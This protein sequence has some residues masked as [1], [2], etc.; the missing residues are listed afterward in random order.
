[1]MES[2]VDFVKADRRLEKSARRMLM[3]MRLRKAD[4]GSGDG[5][6]RQMP[7]AG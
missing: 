6:K 4:V 1:M 5:G 7:A 2:K 3:D